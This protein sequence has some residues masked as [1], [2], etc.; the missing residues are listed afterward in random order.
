MKGV[1]LYRLCM[2]FDFLEPD[3]D[4]KPAKRQGGE[5]NELSEKM[6]LAAKN[7][8]KTSQAIHLHKVER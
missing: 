4:S 3:G 2:F 7:H 1:V 5:A 8:V 6:Q